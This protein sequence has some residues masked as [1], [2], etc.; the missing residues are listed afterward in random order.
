LTFLG[1]FMPLIGAF[2][3]GLAA[4]LIALVFK[5]LVAALIVL[6]AIVVVQQIEGHLLYPV[7]M[8]RT[9]T[10]IPR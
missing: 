10:F 8:S 1:A 4:V 6:G 9:V 3:A 2:L 5:G 7:L